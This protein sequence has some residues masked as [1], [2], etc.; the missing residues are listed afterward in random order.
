M[1]N[2]W[3]PRTL[4]LSELSVIAYAANGTRHITSDKIYIVFSS[5]HDHAIP[6]PLFTITCL[7]CF[8]LLSLA[9]TTL[10]NLCCLHVSVAILYFHHTSISDVY[11]S[12]L[13]SFAFPCFYHTIQSLMFT[14]F[15]CYPLLSL[16]VG[17]PPGSHVHPP[18]PGQ[19]QSGIKMTV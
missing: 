17:G 4:E 13:L 9:F 12:R 3:S 5:N 6:S 19:S 15:S 14:C 1:Y 7:S 18:P 11:M 2:V 8:P 16:V 10:F